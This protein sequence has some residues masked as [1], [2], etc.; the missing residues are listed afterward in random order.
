MGKTTKTGPSAT[1]RAGKRTPKRLPV[2]LTPEEVEA[3]LATVNTKSTTGLRNRAMLQAMIGAG[4]RVSEVTALRGVDV[5]LQKGTVRVNLGKGS[6]DR[7][8]PI[9]QETRAWLYAWSAKRDALGLN[10]RQAFFPGIRTGR[11]GRGDRKQGDAL[12]PRYVQL[13]VS[14][15][16]EA[17]AIE[18]R[19]T[20]HTLRH[21]YATRMLERPGLTI[22]D[23]QTLLGHANVATTQVY[24]HVNEDELR[25]KVQAEDQMQGPTV[26]PQVAALAAAVAGLSEEQR[27]ALAKALT[28]E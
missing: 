25:E 9:D 8:V 19:V 24:T 21:T 13:L 7:V 14:R 5:D 15:L 16:G 27:A 11:T 1:L 10:G 23:V 22:R 12:S 4:L 18:K 6:K 26:D 2:T 17:A 28:G 3:I 20:P